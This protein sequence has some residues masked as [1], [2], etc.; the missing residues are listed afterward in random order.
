M[1]GNVWEWGYDW[2]DSIETGN[3]TAPTGA[4]SGS[5]RVERGGGLDNY[6]NFASV[7]SRISSYP[8]GRYIS[9]GFRVCRSAK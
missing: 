9:L 4:S 1:S 2:Y 3:V 7:C 6:A 8:D 5:G